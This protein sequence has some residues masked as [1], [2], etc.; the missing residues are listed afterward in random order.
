M[1]RP[2][3]AAV[4]ALGALLLAASLPA[5]APEVGTAPLGDAELSWARALRRARE[6]GWPYPLIGRMRGAIEE[7]PAAARPLCDIVYDLADGRIE[8]EP[9]LEVV[10]AC[11]AVLA[12]GTPGDPVA[13]AV[14]LE[15]RADY[16]AEPLLQTVALL[17][18]VH[19]GGQ[20]PD[21]LVKALER[22][23]V[24]KAP[25]AATLQILRDM[26]AARDAVPL[27][28]QA[29]LFEEALGR[30]GRH[31]EADAA[32]A[33]FRQAVR[34]GLP[35]ADLSAACRRRIRTGMQTSRLPGW[36]REVQAWPV[37]PLSRPSAL[38]LIAAGLAYGLP[39]EEVAA[40]GGF[41]ARSSLDAADA[42]V[43]AVRLEANLRRKLRGRALLD[44]TLEG[45]SGASSR[46]P[47]DR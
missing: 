25:A 22:A 1:G 42:E 5:C 46:A 32:V 20:A 24:F 35:S 13:A 4:L 23:A 43:L 30:R 41:V 2:A 38:R 14:Q 3:P 18:E 45:F 47:A 16:P 28:D 11:G 31:A 37:P 7:T 17:G 27:V 40:F 44:G 6:A 29:D 8:P 39:D 26:A 9:A 19:A 34:E 21:P 12:A 15:S 33:A 10:R 36:L